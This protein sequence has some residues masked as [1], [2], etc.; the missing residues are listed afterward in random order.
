LTLPGFGCLIWAVYILPNCNFTE[1]DD[2]KAMAMLVGLGLVGQ[3]ESQPRLP[4]DTFT[5]HT[6]ADHPTHWVFVIKHFGH[7]NPSDNGLSVQ[8]V[9]KSLCTKEIFEKAI[10]GMVSM[11]TNNTRIKI[12]NSSKN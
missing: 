11:N 4:G 7:S 3:L 10:K 6:Y 2:A 9:L 5:A 12:H 8:G 1:N